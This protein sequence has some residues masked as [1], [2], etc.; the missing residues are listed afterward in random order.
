MHLAHSHLPQEDFQ[1]GW[2][3]FSCGL[4]FK[5]WCISEQMHV[6]CME[7]LFFLIYLN[8]LK[9]QNGCLFVPS[10]P[11]MLIWLGGLWSICYMSSIPWGQRHCFHRAITDTRGLSLNL[12]FETYTFSL[13]FLKDQVWNR[14]RDKS[15]IGQC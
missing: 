10:F 3:N 14:G 11:G 1:W 2:N 6:S 4:R 7:L 13:Y 8:V 12:K 5:R 15:I 9:N